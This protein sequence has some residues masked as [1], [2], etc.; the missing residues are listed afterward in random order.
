MFA[1]AALFEK[2]GSKEQRARSKDFFPGSFKLVEDASCAASGGDPRT[3]PGSLPGREE[4]YPPSLTTNVLGRR[5]G[6]GVYR[7]RRLV[8]TVDKVARYVD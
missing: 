7:K 4:P 1:A 5:E 3:G 6:D 2:E 8:R